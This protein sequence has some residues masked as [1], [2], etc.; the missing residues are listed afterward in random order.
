MDAFTPPQAEIVFLHRNGFR[1]T[2]SLFAIPSRRYAVRD[3]S[4]VWTVA[5]P[6]H[7]LVYSAL[8]AAGVVV[9]IAIIASPKL[10][11]VAA[12]IGVAA[13]LAIPLAIAGVTARCRP[14]PMSLFARYRG[15]TELLIESG[16]PTWFRQVCRALNRAREYN[17]QP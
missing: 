11:T 6:R 16:N 13:V 9:V 8:K 17:N 12:W 14:R 5:G 3:L 2:G 4:E 15:R 10:D 7:S 1:I